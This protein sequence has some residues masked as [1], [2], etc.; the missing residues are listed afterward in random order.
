MTGPQ[1]AAFRARLGLTQEQLA[2]HLELPNP[3]N[4][5]K[6]TV[7]R[8]EAGARTP[9]PFLRLALCEVERR[10]TRPDAALA[11]PLHRAARARS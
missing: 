7:A 8:W 10:L 4:G 2:S 1:I 5:G 11:P 3:A 6:V 9:V